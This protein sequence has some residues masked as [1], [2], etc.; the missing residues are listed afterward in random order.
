MRPRS[1]VVLYPKYPKATCKLRPAVVERLVTA[2]DLLHAKGQRRLLVWDCYRPLAIQKVLWQQVPDPRYEANPKTGSRHNR[3]AAVD[4][5]LVDL[6]GKPVTLP[7]AFDDASSGTN[8][9]AVSSVRLARPLT[10]A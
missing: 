3:G 8:E 2:A 9:N 7:T 1:G 10:I 6:D 4:L 5:G